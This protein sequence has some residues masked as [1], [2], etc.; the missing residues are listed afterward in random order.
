MTA[1]LAAASKD[2]AASRAAHTVT[3]TVLVSAFA[4][5]GLEGTFHASSAVARRRRFLGPTDRPRSGG[6]G[7]KSRSFPET[8]K[9]LFISGQNEVDPDRRRPPYH[10]RV[11]PA[12]V[13]VDPRP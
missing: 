10:P 2:A 3:E 7:G 13:Q 4:L 11:L 6:R 8:N 12:N 9:H 5:A 1:L